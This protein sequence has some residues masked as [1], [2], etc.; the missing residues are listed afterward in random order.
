[1]SGLLGCSRKGLTCHG[2]CSCSSCPCLQ[3]LSRPSFGWGGPQD[4]FPWDYD[5]CSSS[6]MGSLIR[7]LFHHEGGSYHDSH[8]RGCHGDNDRDHASFMDAE[9]AG[10][11][12]YFH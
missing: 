9:Q 4:L 1:M 8:G 11:G 7:L 5:F 12:S 10:V 6:E 3:N 2:P